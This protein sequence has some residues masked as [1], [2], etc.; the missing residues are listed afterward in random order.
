M[1]ELN[2][3]I[4]SHEKISFAAVLFFRNPKCWQEEKDGVTSNKI[5]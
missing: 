4:F 3:V 5:I 2:F 1:E